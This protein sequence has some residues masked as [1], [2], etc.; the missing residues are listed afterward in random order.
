MRLMI[1]D[2]ASFMRVAIRRMIERKEYEVVCEAEDGLQAIEKF[3]KYRPDVITMDITMPNLSGIEALKEIKKLS[4]TVKV[5]M[6]SAMGQE[7]LIRE[8]VMHGANSFIVKPFKE[9]KLLEV[10]ESLK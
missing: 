9:D 1:V 4:S 6:V 2:D 8:A 10:L 3:Q 7:A 5:V